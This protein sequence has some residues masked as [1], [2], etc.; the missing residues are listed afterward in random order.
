MARGVKTHK[1]DEVDVMDLRVLKAIAS[2]RT[3]TEA[4]KYLG[5]TQPMIVY[6]IQL[7]ENYFQQPV[8]F[9]NAKADIMTPFGKIL[10][11]YADG[12]LDLYNEMILHARTF[13]KEKAN[14]VIPT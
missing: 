6:R 2:Y 1:L 10:L 11:Q 9:R 3:T 12:I 13:N 14:V 5:V 7:L 8:Y 4:A